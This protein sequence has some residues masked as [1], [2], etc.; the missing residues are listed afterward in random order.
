[1]AA[2]ASLLRDIHTIAVSAA[3]CPLVLQ[4]VEPSDLPDAVAAMEVQPLV[5][6]GP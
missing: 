4:S 6:A 1:M 5:M 3:V 2:I